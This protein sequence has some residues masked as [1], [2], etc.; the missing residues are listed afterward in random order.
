MKAQSDSLLDRDDSLI[1][2]AYTAGLTAAQRRQFSFVSDSLDIVQDLLDLVRRE[3]RRTG[4]ELATDPLLIE[5][6][7]Q[8]ESMRGPLRKSRSALLNIIAEAQLSTTPMSIAGNDNSS[9]GARLS[10]DSFT[11]NSG[12]AA[13]ALESSRVEPLDIRTPRAHN[14]PNVH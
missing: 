13:D 8:A 4:S 5:V 2:S 6:A 11:T 9:E 14:A 3:R 1:D 10:D 7:A 12:P